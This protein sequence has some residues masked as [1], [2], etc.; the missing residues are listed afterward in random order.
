MH[1]S[2]SRQRFLTPIACLL[3]GA[4]ATNG[5]V[6]S[7]LEDIS[8]ES[9]K[10]GFFEARQYRIA[11]IPG[12][13]NSPEVGELYF[14][15][16]QRKPTS[17]IG[18]SNTDKSYIL[19]SEFAGT[20]KGGDCTLKH[21]T[22]IR[23]QIAKTLQLGKALI[24]ERLRI[25]KLKNTKEVEAKVLQDAEKAEA[26]AEKQF[27]ASYSPL[28]V[29]IENSGIFIY[30]WS[31]ASST[32]GS[33]SID[34][35]LGVG[36][37]KEERHN[38]FALVCGLRQQKLYIGQDLEQQWKNINRD[39]SFDNNFMLITGMMQARHIVYSSM[40]DLETYIRA[41]V[42]ASA[43]ELQALPATL[44]AATEIKIAATLS[45]VANL[46]NNGVMSGV[47][48]QIRAVSWKQD[49]MPLTQDDDWLTF[50]AVASELREVRRMLKNAGQ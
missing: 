49:T 24:S 38:G 7:S 35:L 21:L 8:T 12:W 47:K 39:T 25:A 10:E 27:D 42:A 45:S 28:L 3:L 46:S 4:C 36:G 41:N 16:P 48:R 50:Y 1:I 31:T 43:A 19:S 13:L 2:F 14:Y 15:K 6:V 17:A 33:L 34:A 9:Q 40:L 30:R 5:G 20:G 18:I 32:G 37:N 22:D 26:D 29:K 44:K 23:D 11:S